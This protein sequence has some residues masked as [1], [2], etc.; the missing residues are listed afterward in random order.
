M[1]HENKIFLL[2]ISFKILLDFICKKKSNNFP[3]KWEIFQ[4]I[5]I[6]IQT[7]QLYFSNT[8]FANLWIAFYTQKKTFWQRS[9]NIW[10]SVTK[11]LHFEPIKSVNFWSDFLIQ[12]NF[13]K[14]ETF[15]P[16]CY[17][18]SDK[19]QLWNQNHFSSDSSLE[20][21]YKGK[22]VSAW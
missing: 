9:T 15:T 4:N 8:F 19:F 13:E 22:V 17:H 6:S 7:C 21:E 16:N 11:W 18:Y 5:S 1:H 14:T 2:D 12:G 3:I 20:L 10:W